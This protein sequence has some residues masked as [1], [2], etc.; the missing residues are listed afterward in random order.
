MFICM[1]RGGWAKFHPGHDKLQFLTIFQNF[2]A[3]ATI[4]RLSIS[5]CHMFTLIVSVEYGSGYL[6]VLC[7]FGLGNS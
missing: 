2:R 4:L 5:Y 3:F 1:S 7:A 6:S